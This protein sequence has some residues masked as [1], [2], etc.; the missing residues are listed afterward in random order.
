MN[1]YTEN[2]N[3][4]KYRYIFNYTLRFIK[5]SKSFTKLTIFL[6]RKKLTN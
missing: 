5:Y 1:E 6:L 2:I 4:R 3:N